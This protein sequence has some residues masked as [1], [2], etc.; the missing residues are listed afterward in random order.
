MKRYSTHNEEKSV[1]VE[2]FIKTLKNQNYKYMTSV[3]KYVYIHKLDD[4]VNK[5]SN[6]YHTTSKIKPIDVKL[7]TYINFNKENNEQ[8]PKF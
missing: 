3:S 5:Y 1:V 2:K 8:D 6:T 7:N 4:M